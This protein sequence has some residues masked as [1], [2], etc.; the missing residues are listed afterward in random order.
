MR[1]S[2]IVEDAPETAGIQ[3]WHGGRW[4]GPPT[5]QTPRKGRYEAGPGIYLTTHYAT[6]RQYAKGGGKT[7][8]VTLN[9]GFKLA[10]DVLIPMNDAIQFL[11]STRMT[12][13]NKIVA[14]VK[15]NAARRNA[16]MIVS[17]VL[18]NLFVNYQAGSGEAGLALARFLVSHGVDAELERKSNNEN[19]LVV[20]NP[21]IIKSVKPM[22]AKDIPLSMYN[23]PEIR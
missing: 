12:Q 8:L 16:A 6:A 7:M 9:P 23:F 13:R 5:I 11:T 4:D 10:Q 1:Y 15:A 21:A 3:M 14:D 19:W 20:I 17:T 2:E 18:I 22:A